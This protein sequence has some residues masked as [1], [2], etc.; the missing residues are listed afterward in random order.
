MSK[1]NDTQ[2]PNPSLEEIRLRDRAR[3]STIISVGIL[4]VFGLIIALLFVGDFFFSKSYITESLISIIVA[5]PAGWIGH[6]V[7]SFFVE[8]AQAKATESETEKPTQ[9]PKGEQ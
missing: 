1:A 8:K 5:F 6:M 3:D 9:H 7:T 4:F 2:K